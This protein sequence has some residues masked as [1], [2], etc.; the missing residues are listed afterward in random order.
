MYLW[1]VLVVNNPTSAPPLLNLRE[2]VQKTEPAYDCKSG[3]FLYNSN[4]SGFASASE[5]LTGRLCTTFR[6][7]SS[8][9]LPLMVRGISLT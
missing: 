3:R 9:I 5:F 8:T 4:A 7:A 6:T 2:Q 1:R